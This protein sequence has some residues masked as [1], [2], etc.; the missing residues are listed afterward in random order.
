MAALRY[1]FSKTDYD[2]PAFKLF[3]RAHRVTLG[4]IVGL[5]VEYASWAL[6]D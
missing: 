5:A 4:L 6:L 3:G 1:Y 2:R